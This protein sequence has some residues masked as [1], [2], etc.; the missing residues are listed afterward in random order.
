MTTMFNILRKGTKEQI[1]RLLTSTWFDNEELRALAN[2]GE[3]HIDEELCVKNYINIIKKPIPYKV[4][5][6]IGIE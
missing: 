4:L 6:E 3:E 2:S 1:A 5:Q